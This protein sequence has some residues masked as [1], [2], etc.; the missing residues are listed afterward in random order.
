MRVVAER[1]GFLALRKLALRFQAQTFWAMIDRARASVTSDDTERS[2][3][4]TVRMYACPCCGYK[5]LPDRGAYHL[6]PVC[7]WEDE[8]TEPWEYSGP[9]NGTLYEAQQAFL[10]DDR[11][12]RRHSW[13]VR[14]PKAREARE[15]GWRPYQLTESQR[16]Q[17]EAEAAERQREWEA[18]E[19]RLAEEIARDPGGPFEQFN[20]EFALLREVAPDMRHRDV[21]ARL[22]EL[23]LATGGRPFGEAHLEL[24]SRV[25][26]DENY[27]RGHPLRTG[28]WLVR[29]ARPRTFTRRWTEV[30][31]G[32]FTF[33]A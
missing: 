22:R 4:H 31:S 25:L 26:A 9:N 12:H 30:R 24:M 14:A 15:P 17:I 7:W 6:C 3:S 5:T 27:Y 16:A 1:D 33:L 11:P 13:K 23:A 29:F 8:G 2:R 21:K 20:A 32:R 10:A 18:E 28:V 19:R